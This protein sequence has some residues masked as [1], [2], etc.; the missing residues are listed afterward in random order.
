[1]AVGSGG[2]V[3]D[4]D[5]LEGTPTAAMLA[6]RRAAE[7]AKERGINAVHVKVR[8]PGG[9]NGPWVPTPAA[10]AAIKALINAGLK[11]GIIE[12]V[13]PIPH[14]RCRRKGGKRGRRV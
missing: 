8:A 12:D 1:M 9:H 14:D 3:V 11:I 4:A 6:A 2:M 7:L 5:R 10:Q 13:T